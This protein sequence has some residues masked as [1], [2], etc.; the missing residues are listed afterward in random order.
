MGAGNRYQKLDEYQTMVYEQIEE[1]GGDGIWLKIIRQRTNMHESAVNHAIK[2]LTSM[3]LISELKNVA[4]SNRRIFIKVGV[5]Q[6]ERSSGGPWYTD[7]EL[8]EAFIATITNVLYNKILTDSMQL[9]KAGRHAMDRFQRKQMEAKARLEKE[10][11]RAK[12][13]KKGVKSVNSADAADA[14]ALRNRALGPL[15]KQAAEMME[16][17]MQRTLYDEF[18]HYPA[19]YIDYPKIDPLTLW[20][21]ESKVCHESVVLTTAEVGVVLDI[22]VLDKK[23]EEVDCGAYGIGYK[24]TRQSLKPMQ[25][26]FNV[27]TEAPCGRCP[28][29]DLCEEGGPVGPS[30]C[31]YFNKWLGV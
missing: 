16:Y 5:A 11:Q 23:I 8:D 25:D 24:V 2:Q 22:M 13:P 17:K 20:V 18:V 21:M 6:S 9:S 15:E 1:S 19:G 28:V 3:G 10:Q 4:N 27:F 30:N 7:G 26:A 31:E 12:Q 14:E 29:F